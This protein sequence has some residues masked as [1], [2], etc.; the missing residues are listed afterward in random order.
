MN[1]KVTNKDTQNMCPLLES[2]HWDTQKLCP[3]LGSEH[4]DTQKIPPPPQLQSYKK[5]EKFKFQWMVCEWFR[6][7]SPSHQ[8]IFSETVFG[9]F[10]YHFT[11]D[12]WSLLLW[13][14]PITAQTKSYPQPLQLQYC[15][16]CTLY[17]I[18]DTVGGDTFIAHSCRLN[19]PHI[20]A[21][22]TPFKK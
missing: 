8:L 9:G 22:L 14:A 5:L 20:E 17:A 19:N 16:L 15:R 1:I 3:P 12:I 4:W 18:E 6:T 11:V 7:F 21:N 2:E 13:N 10:F